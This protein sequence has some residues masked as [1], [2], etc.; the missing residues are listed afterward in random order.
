MNSTHRIWIGAGIT[1]FVLAA[2]LSGIPAGAQ[3]EQQGGQQNDPSIGAQQ[4]PNDQYPNGQDPNAQAPAPD[5]QQ[6][7]AQD[8]PP[9]NQ[10][11]VPSTLTL[12]AGTVLSVRT[13]GQ[14]SSERNQVGDQF[15]ATL[16]QPLIANGWVVGRRGQI[17]TGRVVVADKGSHSKPSQLG[18][19]IIEVT[20]VDG[21][22]L[23]V[24][25]QLTRS[26]G[27]RSG[28]PGRDVATV[29][30]TTALGAIIGAVAGGGTGAAIGA[31]V[32]ATAGGA[33]VLSTRGNPTILYAE[34]PLTF[35]LDAPLQ[36]STEQSQVA[37][38][39]VK[40]SDYSRA[41]G[42]QDLY[43]RPRPN[44]GAGP[45]GP[46]GGP[47]YYAPYPYYGGYYPFVPYVGFY[48]YYGGFYGPRFYGGFRR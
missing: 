29:G 15:S 30:T 22:V 46:Y 42:D 14:L 23:P 24:N 17:V 28:P 1:S 12:P 45:Y 34:T 20:L 10:P 36:I 21:Q 2:C 32:G 43:A 9:A 5:A 40:Q 4:A 26:S 25:T 33:V 31:G 37:F 27:G 39:P 48:G 47:A 6:P 19:Q 18:V 38:Q 44:R 8:A 7:A 11:P 13:T 3:S 41:G 16:E 35:R